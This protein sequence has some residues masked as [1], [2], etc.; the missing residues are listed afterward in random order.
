MFREFGPAGALLKTATSQA[1][2]RRPESQV[3]LIGPDDY[4]LREHFKHCLRVHLLHGDIG[5]DYPRDDIVQALT[6][7]GLWE[8]DDRAVP[9]A[10]PRWQTE[11]GK[12]IF[13]AHFRHQADSGRYERIAGYEE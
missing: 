5:A 7:L 11:L 13:A 4:F 3:E 2:F 6:D 9:F 1:Y 10:D 8:K 12:E